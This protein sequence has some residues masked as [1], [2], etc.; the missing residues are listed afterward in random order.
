MQVRSSALWHVAA[1]CAALP[2][3][4]LAAQPGDPVA[5]S[6]DF[7]SYK[8]GSDGSPKW[9]PYL[10]R[11][12]MR[13]GQCEQT[14]AAAHRAYLFLP[15]P[16]LGDI[17]FSVRFKPSAEGTGVRAAG[18]VFRAMNNLE[19]YYAHFDSRNSQVIL[20]RRRRHRPWFELARIRR[21]PIAPDQWHTGRIV[22]KGDLIQV[23]LDGKQI[24]EKRDRAFPAGAVGLRCGQGHVAFDDLTVKGARPPKPRRFA[25]EKDPQDES[26][27][28]RIEGA[29]DMAAVK[30]SGYF[31]V[32][33]RLK[34]GALGAV[35]RGGAG[36]LGLKGRLDW[37]RSDD[38]GKTW[39]EPKVIVD[40]QVDDRNPGLGVMADGTVVMA[41][42]EASTYNAQGKFDRTCG[43]YELFY[44]LSTDGGRTWSDKIPLAPD[45]LY[46]GSPY[47]RIITLS[48]GTALMQ[49]YVWEDQ[50]AKLPGKR[51]PVPARCAGILRSTDN[52]RTWGDW[53]TVAKGYNEISLAEMPGGRL[54]A[55]MRS[56]R[57][58]CAVCMSTDK[59]R[60]W[61]Q[62]Q[63][64]TKVGQH[65]P[66]LCLLKSGALLMPF[67]CRLVPRGVQAVLSDDGG[68]SWA[69]DR[70]VFLAWKAL[71]GDCGY[72]SAVTLDDGT[73]VLLYYAVGTSDLPGRQC[74]CVRFTE[75]QVRKARGD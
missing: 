32:L 4:V 50:A 25:M 35:V 14:D 8:E 9:A 16:V 74:R 68:K 67:G 11:W 33:V 20:V 66:D 46:S 73:I 34:G 13:G 17:D 51:T 2:L 18:M 69:F 55:A 54:V 39:S 59:G 45:L 52:G 43:R 58:D 44:V 75:Q 1:L 30:G 61:S 31:P 65:P 56:A 24:A 15:E 12:A 27:A 6:D 5:A 28:P 37:I 29:E 41:Y 72:P 7:S 36:H 62:P 23:H 49:I 57:G 42:G 3:A 10:G 60:S 47:G 38:G 48:D 53:S 70:R 26:A 19:L 64:V 22:C 21:V 71:S 63:T 40:S